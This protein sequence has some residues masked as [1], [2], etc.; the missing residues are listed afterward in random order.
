MF[1]CSTGASQGTSSFP[2][3]LLHLRLH[4]HPNLSLQKFPD[5]F[6]I[7]EPTELPPDERGKPKELVVDLCRHQHSPP[8]LVDIQGMDI[9]RVTSYKHLGVHLNN[10]LDWSVN[11][12]TLFKKWQIR[13]FLPRILRSFGVLDHFWSVTLQKSA[14]QATG[15]SVNQ[16]CQLCPGLLP[17]F[18][19]GSGG[20]PCCHPPLQDTLSIALVSFFS[21]RL[22]HPRCVKDRYHFFLLLWDST[23]SKFKMEYLSLICTRIHMQ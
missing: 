9:K 21:R 6:A 22:F 3:H 12:D 16:H 20:L 11:T 13:L 5:D 18:S 1:L 4:V 2:V 7:L 23:I 14:G 10:K 17:G 8:A 15:N 19:G